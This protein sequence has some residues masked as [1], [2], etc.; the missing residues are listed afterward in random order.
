MWL[1]RKGKAYH[2]YSGMG[3]FSFLRKAEEKAT[4][5]M[6]LYSRDFWKVPLHHVPPLAKAES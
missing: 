6:S 4:K 5:S 3:R 1:E 2:Q